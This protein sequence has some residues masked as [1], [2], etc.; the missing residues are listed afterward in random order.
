LFAE[1]FADLFECVMRA[2]GV[3]GEAGD[4]AGGECSGEDCGVVVS[5]KVGE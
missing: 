1:S 2:V 3:L 4:V 5:A